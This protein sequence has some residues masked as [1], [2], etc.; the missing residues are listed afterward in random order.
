MSAG[1]EDEQTG[2]RIDIAGLP[3]THGQ[4]MSTQRFRAVRIV[5]RQSLRMRFGQGAIGQWLSS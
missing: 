4:G 3:L 2:S 1:G 5:K